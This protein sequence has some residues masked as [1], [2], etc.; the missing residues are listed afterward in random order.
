MKKLNQY[1]LTMEKSI[2]LI[3]VPTIVYNFQYGLASAQIAKII[4]YHFSSL[5]LPMFQQ[6][7][8]YFSCSSFLCLYSC[9]ISLFLLF[10]SLL[11]FSLSFP[12]S[13]WNVLP[14]KFYMT[15]FTPNVATSERPSLTTLMKEVVP[16]YVI[17]FT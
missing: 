10:P 7:C 15:D 14:P 3:W 6:H 17:L 8:F 1:N 5:S 9:C 11:S 4:Q 12:L 2:Y 16:N 13:P